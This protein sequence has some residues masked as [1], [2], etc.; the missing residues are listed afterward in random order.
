[1]SVLSK[2]LP[3]CQPNKVRDSKLDEFPP[4]APLGTTGA[5][6]ADARGVSHGHPA[7]MQ[8]FHGDLAVMTFPESG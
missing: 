6:I 3:R 2:L 5:S 7:L 4:A 8:R 1:M